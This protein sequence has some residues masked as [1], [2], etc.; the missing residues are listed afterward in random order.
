MNGKQGGS[1]PQQHQEHQP[2]REWQM[3]PEPDY[4][5][6]YAGSGKLQGK[7][8]VITGGDSGIGRAT[9]ILFAR[10]GA[11]IAILFL[12]ETE[13]ARKTQALVEG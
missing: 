8:A 1:L 4:R 9:A 3:E 12:E 7:V 11:E 2:G 10:E 13:D 6:R 5:P